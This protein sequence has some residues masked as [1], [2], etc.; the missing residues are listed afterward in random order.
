MDIILSIILQLFIVIALYFSRGFIEKSY[1]SHKTKNAAYMVVE[2]MDESF[3]R[4]LSIYMERACAECSSAERDVTTP[5][6]HH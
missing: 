6:F 4:I 3:A 5:V 2:K 1:S